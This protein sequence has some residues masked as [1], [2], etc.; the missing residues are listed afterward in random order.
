[1]TDFSEYEVGKHLKI[2]IVDHGDTIH[3][4]TIE[5]AFTPFTISPILLVSLKT[6]GGSARALPS[7]VNPITQTKSERRIGPT[8]PGS[9]LERCNPSTRMS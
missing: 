5:K 1:M 9:V 6:T 8:S 7:S 2:K 3:T 4:D